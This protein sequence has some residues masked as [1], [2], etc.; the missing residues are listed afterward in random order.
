MV[1]LLHL[2]DESYIVTGI[3]ANHI[4]IELTGLP[5]SESDAGSNRIDYTCIG[6]LLTIENT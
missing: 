4:Q 6:G 5:P 1:R 2:S 3:F